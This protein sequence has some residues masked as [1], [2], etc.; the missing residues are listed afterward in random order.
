MSNLI[1]Q[2]RGSCP[3]KGFRR[4]QGQCHPGASA[5]NGRKR[6]VNVQ[7]SGGEFLRKTG[8]YHAS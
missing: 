3:L 5:K 7:E 2:E 1:W 6:G 4:D 8:W